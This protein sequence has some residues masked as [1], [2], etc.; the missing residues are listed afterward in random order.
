MSVLMTPRK[1][2]RAA[3]LGKG[4]AGLVGTLALVVGVPAALLTWVGSP[5]PAGMPSGSDVVGALRDTYIPDE[6]LVKALALVCWLVWIELVASLLVEGVAYARGR[7]A[8]SVPLAGGL[9]RGAARLVAT[10]ALLGVLVASRGPSTERAAQPLA[11]VAQQPVAMSLVVDDDPKTD[12]DGA[13][14]QVAPDDE[15]VAAAPVYEVQ[16]RDTLW[17]IAERHLGDPF[18]WQEIF[19]LNEGCPQADGGC[20]TDPDLIFAGWQ[21]ELPADAVGIAEV[22]PAPAP[23]APAPDSSE[24]PAPSPT[25]DQSSVVLDGGMVLID[26][27]SGGAGGSGPGS[28]DGGYSTG[29]DPG[30]VLVVS[31]APSPAGSA[32]GGAADGVSGGMVLLPDDAVPA[33]VGADGTAVLAGPPPE[34]S[35]PGPDGA[36]GSGADGGDE[37]ASGPDGPSSGSAGASGTPPR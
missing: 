27:G 37:L 8:G 15:A 10:V 1:Q 18:R 33:P 21:L 5:L 28:V 36:D 24:A 34:G 13:G 19:Q 2:N 11:A 16:R 6:F 20:L 31:R 29:A 25:D 3:D 12:L 35:G 9:Q 7:K 32:V 17:D 30:D 23:A 22:T 26:D 14:S 4:L